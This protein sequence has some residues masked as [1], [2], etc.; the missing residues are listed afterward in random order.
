[1]ARPTI[2]ARLD[3]LPKLPR[4]DGTVGMSELQIELC[5]RLKHWR[6]NVAAEREIESS[7]LLN[8]HVM[9]R[10]AMERPGGRDAL[11][12]VEGVLDWQMEMF[13]EG[14]IE[15]LSGFERAVE[16]GEVPRARP[17]RR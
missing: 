13:G 10:I 1:M 4:K 7:Y 17:W 8:R 15:V 14:L 9:A 16:A 6:K 5:E 3:Y 11:K 2:S 12:Q